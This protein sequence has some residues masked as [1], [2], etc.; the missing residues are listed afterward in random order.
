MLRGVAS[1]RLLQTADPCPLP[2]PSLRNLSAGERAG[3][4]ALSGH[5]GRRGSDPPFFVV[6]DRW[7]HPD[8][9]GGGHRARASDPTRHILF[10]RPIFLPNLKF[11]GPCLNDRYGAAEEAEEKTQSENLLDSSRA[12]FG[13]PLFQKRLGREQM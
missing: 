4:N 5:P 6:T 8:Q 2:V 3:E 12:K 11:P 10:D 7:I 9:G 13:H 1:P